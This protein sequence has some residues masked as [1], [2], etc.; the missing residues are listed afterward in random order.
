MTSSTF[1]LGS[2]S[3][4]GSYISPRHA[5]LLAVQPGPPP[6]TTSS[7]GINAMNKRLV[8]GSARPETVAMTDEVLL[9]GILNSSG[10][11][12]RTAPCPTPVG[13]VSVVDAGE[14]A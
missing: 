13:S 7:I 9:R 6:L 5:R 10:R 4:V 8:W 3:Q 14:A 12:G 2:G 1:T 11:G